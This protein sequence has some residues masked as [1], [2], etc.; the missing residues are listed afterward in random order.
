MRP[1]TA[2]LF[3]LSELSLMICTAIFSQR[4][5]SGR[6]RENLMVTQKYCHLKISAWARCS[7]TS[8]NVN[9]VELLVQPRHRALQYCLRTTIGREIRFFSGLFIPFLPDISWSCILLVKKKDQFV[10]RSLSDL[11]SPH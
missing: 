11:P 6:L 5:K 3:S 7:G 8:K 10:L 1:A 9:V 4:N 2:D